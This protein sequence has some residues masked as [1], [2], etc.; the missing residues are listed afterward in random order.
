MPKGSLPQF[1][2][3]PEKITPIAWTNPGLTDFNFMHSSTM[4]SQVSKGKEEPPYLR[5]GG[6]GLWRLSDES[7][8]ESW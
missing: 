3:Y 5:H 2:S 1:F 6:R 7:V 8:K 4:Q